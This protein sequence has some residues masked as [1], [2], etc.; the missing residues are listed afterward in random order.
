MLTPNPLQSKKLVQELAVQA[1]SLQRGQRQGCEQLPLH[2]AWQRLHAVW[3][4]SSGEG[5]NFVEDTK[6]AALRKAEPLQHSE[7]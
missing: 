1:G 5:V 3:V 7:C 4:S 2:T 6:H